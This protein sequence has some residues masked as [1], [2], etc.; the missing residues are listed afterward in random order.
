MDA[1]F[2]LT[3]MVN[4]LAIPIAGPKKINRIKIDKHRF[5]VI[6]FHL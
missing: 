5:I 2:C 4:S 3:S 6:L 1:R